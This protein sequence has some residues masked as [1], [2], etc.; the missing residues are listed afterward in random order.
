MSKIVL[1]TDTHLGVRNGNQTILD[2]QIRF[3]EGVLF[4][5]MRDKG[6]RTIIH[7]GDFFDTRSAISH[8]TIWHAQW[9]VDA[10]ESFDAT[11]HILVGNHDIPNKSDNDFDATSMLL[12]SNNVRVYSKN[13]LAYPEDC[14]FAF[15]PWVNK[16]NY[17]DF[18][19]FI[20]TTKAK[21]LFGHFDFLGAKFNKYDQASTHGIDPNLVKKF[22]K[23]FSGHFHTKSTL[24]NIEYLGAPFEYTW[25]DWDDP[26]GFHVFN[27]E[28]GKL[29]F[30]K[31]PEK[32]FYKVTVA[33]DG[34]TTY[35]PEIKSNQDLSGKFVM[36]ESFCTDKK[37]VQKL[38]EGIGEVEDLQVTVKPVETLLEEIE[39]KS[40][41]TMLVDG[42]QSISEKRRDGVLNI[43]QSAMDAAKG[44]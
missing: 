34:A 8:K 17:N 41:D 27:D 5:Y 18:V 36:V 29:T 1:I 26:K 30:V 3:Y 10:L 23:V 31:N 7:L 40:L 19:S 15:V 32:L 11:M 33:E 4:P 38:C 43:L 16:N 20:E 25:A 35:V 37:V 39:V 24:G 14:G 13:T 9:F 42:V 6:I 21:Y 12:K 2:H 22:D 44:K 28:T